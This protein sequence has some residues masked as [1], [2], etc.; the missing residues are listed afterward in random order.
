VRRGVRC[1][2]DA[3]P[4]HS[5]IAQLAL[6]LR[7]PYIL[8]SPTNDF[9][10]ADCQELLANASAAFFPLDATVQLT[11]QGTLTPSKSPGELFARFTPQPRDIDENLARHAFALVQQLES[12]R[13]LPPPTT[14]AVFRLYCIDALSAAQAA[15]KCHCSKATILNRLALIRKKTGL[16]P[17]KLRTL[18]PHIAKIEN[19]ISDPRARHI[20]RP[21]AI[22]DHP[23]G[24]E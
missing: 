4:L 12:E 15:R 11:A 2:R 22:D 18:S 7:Q 5:V 23:S 13:P 9:I 17:A 1:N 14:L 21:A 16:D 6:R 10:D 3:Y 19:E 24:E 8:F 20:H